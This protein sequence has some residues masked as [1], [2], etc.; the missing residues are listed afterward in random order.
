M[1]TEFKTPN[2]KGIQIKAR[3]NK[4]LFDIS[5]VGGGEVPPI[6]QGGFTSVRMAKAQ[7][8]RYLNEQTFRVK[9]EEPLKKEVVKKKPAKNAKSK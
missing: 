5:F 2:G 6:I 7:I 9:K 8:K 4:M 3:E 1:I